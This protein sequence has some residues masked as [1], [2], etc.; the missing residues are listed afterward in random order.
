MCR[1]RFTLDRV[2]GLYSFITN[3]HPAMIIGSFTNVRLYTSSVQVSAI[4]EDYINITI[5]H[6]RFLKMQNVTSNV[7]A[8][9]FAF[10]IEF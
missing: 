5:L 6:L 10:N 2:D 8:N 3:R 4:H 7:L 9:M 1:N